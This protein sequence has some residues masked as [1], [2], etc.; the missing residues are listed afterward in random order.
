MNLRQALIEQGP[1]L[2]LQREAQA[3]IARLDHTLRYSYTRDEL[4]RACLAC[5]IPPATFES[6][7][8][9]LER[10]RKKFRPTT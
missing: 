7:S 9:E 1:S 2:A 8:I 10:L 4:V 5:E 6:L 3:E